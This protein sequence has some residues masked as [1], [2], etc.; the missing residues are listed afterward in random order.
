MKNVQAQFYKKYFNTEP[1]FLLDDVILELDK[2]RQSKFI[3][4]LGNYNQLFI[5]VTDKKYSDIFNNKKALNIIEV[6]NGKIL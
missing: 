5:T 3:N 2:E 6:D 1:V 4:Y